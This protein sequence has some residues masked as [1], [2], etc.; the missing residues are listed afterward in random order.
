MK[1]FCVLILAVLALSACGGSKSPVSSFSSVSSAISSSSVSSS[2]SVV[3]FCPAEG[4]DKSGPWPGFQKPINPQRILVFTK[5]A[6]F[7]HDSIPAGRNMLQKLAQEQGWELELTE[8]A[9]A[10]TR[11]NLARFSAV[12]WLSTTG[13]LLNAQQ[14]AAF[15]SYIDNGGGYLGIHA[16]ADTEYNWPWYGELVGAYFHSHP[17]NQSAVI[18][19]E[20]RNHPATRHLDTSW[21]HFDEWYNFQSNPRSQVEVLM[22]LDESSYAPG[23][24][25]MGDHPIA[26]YQRVG[27][28]RAFYTGLGHTIEAYSNPNFVQHIKGALIW[29]GR[30]DAD[31]PAWQGPPPPDADFTVRQL[32]TGINLPM[33]LQISANNDI[34][35]I[36]RQ[37]EFYAYESGELR[38]KSTLS[39]N[40]ANEGGL[41]GFVLDPNFLTNRL[42][43]LHYTDVSGVQHHVSRFSL[44]ADNTLNLASEKR[45]LSYP[46]DRRCCHVAG[47]MAFDSEDN[48]YIAT[49]DNTDP[50][51]SN[52]Y[53]PIDERPGRELFDAQRTSANTNSLRGK[54]LRIKP[55]ADGSYTIPKG[56]L[57]AADELHRGE[58]YAM[59]L[60]NPFRIALDSQSDLLLWGDVGPDADFANVN[61][62]PT[63]Y[64]EIN[65]TL[66]PGNFGWPYFA[67][68]NQ[69]YNDF[70]FSSNQSGSKFDPEA[71]V[72]NSVNNTGANLLPSAR[73][74]WI[75]LSHRATM[76]AGV[77]RWNPAVVDPYKLPSYFH[78]RLLYWNFNNDAFFEVAVNESEPV[79]RRWLNTSLLKGIIDGSISPANNRLYLLAYGG[80]CC[81]SPPFAGTL[82]EVRYTGKGHQTPEELPSFG[83]GDMVRFTLDG[84]IVSVADPNLELVDQPRGNS[85]IFEIVDAGQGSVALRSMG[86]RLYVTVMD[87]LHVLLADSKSIGLAQRFELLRNQDG[88]YLLKSLSNC[89]Y[90]GAGEY[91]ELVANRILPD[92]STVFV[93]NQAN[94]CTADITHGLGCRWYTKPYLNMPA[95]PDV[96]WENM[97]GLLSQ[98]GAFAHVPSLTPAESMIPYDL[99]SPLWSDR[100]EKF[101]WVSVP[102]G[103]YVEWAAQ[104]KWSWP[105]GT[106]FV[107]H[108]EL[109][110]HENDPLMVKRLETRL[111]VVQ[112]EGKVYGATYKWRDDN[113]DADLLYTSLDE[114]IEIQS[115]QGNWTQTWTYPGPDDCLTCHNAEAKGVL[116][117]K[118]ASLNKDWLY[119][120]RWPNRN[121]IIENQLRAW[122]RL[123]IFSQRLDDNAIDDLPAHAAL[124]DQSQPLELRLRSYWDIN[125]ANCHGI[126]GIASL[127]DARFETPLESQGI[128]NGA[129]AGHQNYLEIYGLSDPRIVSPG[130]KENSLMYIRDKSSDPDIRMPP[131]G[132]QMEDKRYL[133][134]L[135]AW[136]NSL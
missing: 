34:Y 107:K 103:S 124:D 81:D 9:G 20:N 31:V 99:I 104:G 85:D 51:E 83:V 2:S 63:G 66:V 38:L 17:H 110:V 86:N 80:N 26:W 131:I 93:L 129:V 89:Q 56:N 71:V 27:A 136:I 91:G 52:G 75:S 28:G 62:G 5:T 109:P 24:G 7:R 113:S 33:V 67:G 72:N 58:I 54:I 10:F 121:S 43:Y 13:D 96:Q 108:F 111:L 112:E 64:D 14:K 46:V 128:I 8:D 117:V 122:N 84:K 22:S 73:T 18:Q 55:A 61:R 90:I 30:L 115:P 6:G 68:P 59:G 114:A 70:D 125:C 87:T 97:P 16:A 105:A 40:S 76:L 130:N 39:V 11:E 101:R 106:V 35:V 3:A 98:T 60:R 102:T 53:A 21:R 25:A 134:L 69:A 95:V 123:G 88:S 126:Q 127:W 82:A 37:G 118:T 45:L 74:A 100:A 65:Q 116:G 19:I 57:F 23:A 47:D 133:N 120:P 94:P 1:A 29:V 77:Y 48:L 4:P 12:V 119:P 132:R 79:S 42:L 32:A 50:F 135:E 78:G 44:D 49:G 41:T 15:E 36:G 92:S